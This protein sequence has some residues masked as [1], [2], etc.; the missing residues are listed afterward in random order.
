MSLPFSSLIWAERSSHC[1]VSNGSATSAG[2]NWASIF[3]PFESSRRT[4]ILEPLRVVAGE[5]VETA[6]AMRKLLLDWKR[7]PNPSSRHPAILNRIPLNKDRNQ[8]PPGAEKL[9]PKEQAPQGEC[10]SW[11]TTYCGSRQLLPQPV[12]V[13][14]E[15]NDSRLR[16]N[17]FQKWG[18]NH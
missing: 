12:V 16:V 8:Q 11:H 15:F 17:S 1:T 9:A 13:R 7:L 10:L 14:R 6:L 4:S 2:Q 5:R 3:R 18:V